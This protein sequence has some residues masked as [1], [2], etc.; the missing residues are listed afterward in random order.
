M[1][2]TGEQIIQRAISFGTNAKTSHT[3]PK[4]IMKDKYSRQES[5]SSPM[6]ETN[7]MRSNTIF[8]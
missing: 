1:I 2:T 5:R 7:S 4:A 3:M 6:D 8:P